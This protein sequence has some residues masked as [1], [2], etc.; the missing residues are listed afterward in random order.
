MIDRCRIELN[1]YEGKATLLL[2]IIESTE[3]F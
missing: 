3:F 1:D 2:K